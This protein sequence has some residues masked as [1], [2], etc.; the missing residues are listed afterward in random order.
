MG[1]DKLMRWSKL[2][3]DTRGATAVEF[4]IICPLIFASVLGTFETGRALYERNR[5]SAACA[6]GARAVTLSGASDEAAIEA[7]VRSKFQDTQQEDVTVLLTD[8]TISGGNFKKIAVTYDHDMIVNLGRH[9]SGFSFTVTRYAPATS[10]GG[11]S[12]GSGGSSGS[13][14]GSGGSAGGSGG[15]GGGDTAGS[16]TCKGNGKKSC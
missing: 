11:G 3:G 7:A 2:L 1:K 5:I 12:A 13:G 10:G 6:A 14:G 9:L 16:G 4:A 15:S 8:E